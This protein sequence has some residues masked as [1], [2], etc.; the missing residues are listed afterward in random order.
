ME[1]DIRINQ[2]PMMKMTKI[3]Y[4]DNDEDTTEIYLALI[5]RSKVKPSKAARTRNGT[6]GRCL[7][8]VAFHGFTSL[9]ELSD[10]F[11]VDGMKQFTQQITFDGT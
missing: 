7:A 9:L 11:S 6:F 5:R 8:F 1:V 3:H 2:K 10:D 4:D